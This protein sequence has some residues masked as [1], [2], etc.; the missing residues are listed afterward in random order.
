MANPNATQM[1]QLLPPA[2]VTIPILVLAGYVTLLITGY[3]TSLGV[4]HALPLYAYLCVL[5][6]VLQITISPLQ[7][8]TRVG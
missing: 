5:L 7:S 2:R 4:L 3:D 1:T 6:L 8:F